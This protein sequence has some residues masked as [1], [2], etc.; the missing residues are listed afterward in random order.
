MRQVNPALAELF[1]GFLTTRQH[2][3]PHVAW[4]RV[5][6]SYRWQGMKLLVEIKQ[7][8]GTF[9]D[10]GC[11]NEGGNLRFP[12]SAFTALTLAEYEGTE[13]F[14]SFSFF[15]QLQTT[16]LCPS[17]GFCYGELLPSANR[18]FISSL[19]STLWFLMVELSAK[20]TTKRKQTHRLLCNSFP[21][22]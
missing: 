9:R 14:L 11:R 13:P 4:I 17:G 19:Q 5:D 10:A 2:G 21:T 15:Q 12:F 22:N 1:S 7:P 18:L 8:P 3:E 16:A 6:E 20:L